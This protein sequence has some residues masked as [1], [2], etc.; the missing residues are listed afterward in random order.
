MERNREQHS[1][2]RDIEQ[3][4]R[5]VGRREPLPEHL[6]VGWEASFRS[7]LG[8]VVNRR[9]RRRTLFA[10]AIAASIACVA[11]L[12]TVTLAPQRALPVATQVAY[13]QGDVSV[14]GQAASIGQ[15]LAPGDVLAVAAGAALS[16]ELGG[17]DL[18]LRHD[19][20]LAVEGATIRLA[21]GALYASSETRRVTIP[22]LTV[23]TP[24]ATIRNTGTQF[25]VE[26]DAQ[27]SRALVRRGKLAIV[28]AGATTQLTATGGT[29]RGATLAPDGPTDIVELPARGE[30]W[31][32]IH[33]S[34]PP[35]R[36]DGSSA[37]E[38]LL[39]EARE[40]GLDLVFLTAGSEL[41]AR[42][43]TLHGDVGQLAPLEALHPVL[44]ATDL[45]AT[46]DQGEL[47]VSLERSD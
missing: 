24:H 26:A 29:A 42:T 21:R 44:G 18:R 41:Y 10:A 45:R 38:F 27:G 11:V 32:W 8:A 5:A 35:F 40:N 7:E 34:T 3:I 17:Y 13:V 39:W 23:I 25:I 46:I 28:H 22:A 14:N 2:D 33:A 12:M 20:E 19:S 37:Y 36:I 6:K 47:R 43:T 30:R 9:R 31:D 4:L 15:Q 16:L 1:E